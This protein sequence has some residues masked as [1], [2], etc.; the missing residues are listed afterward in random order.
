MAPSALA[1]RST[2]VALPKPSGGRSK[3]LTG[4]DKRAAASIEVFAPGPSVGD[5]SG[6]VGDLVG[7]STHHGGA[8]KAVYAFAREEL[9]HWE[10]DLGRELHDGHFGENLT[11]TGV[12]WASLVVGQGMQIGEAVLEVSIPRQPCQTFAIHM[13]VRGWTKRFVMRGD[14]GAYLRVVAPGLIR[15]GDPIELAGAPSHGVTVGTAFAAAM[16]DDAA[17]AEVVT[18]NCLPARYHDVLAERLRAR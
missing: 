18:A 16:G 15:P 3:R 13:A 14:C 8:D 11:T 12:T 4:I 2:N 17:A 7:N 1:V 10:R 9:D 6:V 5:G